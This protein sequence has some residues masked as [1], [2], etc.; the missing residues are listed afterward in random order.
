MNT[1]K[2]TLLDLGFFENN[3]FLDL[4]LSLIQS[5]LKTDYKSGVTERHHIIPRAIFKL[6]GEDS[7]SKAPNKKVNKNNIV[8]L[9]YKDHL[10]AHYYLALS[11]K[12]KYKKLACYSFT[13][14]IGQ[15]YKDKRPTLESFSEIDI[16]I[17]E[18]LKYEANKYMLENTKIRNKHIYKEDFERISIESLYEYYIIQKHTIPECATYFNTTCANISSIL[19]YYNIYKRKG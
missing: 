11:S 6:L 13:R 14:M 3:K 18:Q 12:D 9:S 8:N 5:N 16:D 17:Y 2:Q 4:Y 1:L 7:V 10:L 19:K 15:I